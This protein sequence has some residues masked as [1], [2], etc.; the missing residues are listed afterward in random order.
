MPAVGLRPQGQ[1]RPADVIGNAVKVM[2]IA[3]G[4]EAEE[5]NDDGKDP[6]AKAL[7][8]GGKARTAIESVHWR[9]KLD[10]AKLATR[11]LHFYTECNFVIDVTRAARLGAH[12]GR[13]RA[14]A[15][16]AQD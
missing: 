12:H 4:E 5:Y 7:A 16:S 2:R 15:G 13:A 9:P 8:F 6:A 1:K 14:E 10:G 3:I 11:M